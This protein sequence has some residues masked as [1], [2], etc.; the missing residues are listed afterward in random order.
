MTV[1]CLKVSNTAWKTDKDDNLLCL[2][3]VVTCF[4][5]AV[6]FKEPDKHAFSEFFYLFA[7]LRFLKIIDR[8]IFQR[9]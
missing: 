5:L 8:Q 4:Y 1:K 9:F 3:V 2:C 7:T 6:F